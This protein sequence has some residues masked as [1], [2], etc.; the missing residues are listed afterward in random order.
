[1]GEW[2][3]DTFYSYFPSFN[4]LDQKRQNLAKDRQREYQEYLKR[5][6]ESEKPKR[7]P[8]KNNQVAPSPE[9]YETTYHQEKVEDKPPENSDTNIEDD[10]DKPESTKRKLLQDLRHTSLNTLVNGDGISDRNKESAEKE[11]KKKIEYQKQLLRQIEEKRKEVE[12]LKRR[13]KLEEE[14]LAKKL[15]EQLKTMQLEDELEKERIKAE[16][17]RLNIEQNQ[18]LRMKLLQNLSNDAKLLERRNPKTANDDNKVYKY[19]SNSSRS[20]YNK[21]SRESFFDISDS[22]SDQLSMPKSSGQFSPDDCIFYNNGVKMSRRLDYKSNESLENNSQENELSSCKNCQRPF[23]ASNKTRTK[24]CP[25]CLH[26]RNY[27]VDCMRS[28]C[29]YCGEVT[30]DTNTPLTTRSLPTNPSGRSQTNSNRSFKVLDISY[31]A[32]IKDFDYKL[33][34]QNSHPSYVVEKSYTSK[35]PPLTAYNPESKVIEPKL[36]MTSSRSNGATP[37]EDET[38][39]YV[40]ARNTNGRLSKYLRNYGDLSNKSLNFAK[41]NNSIKQDSQKSKISSMPLLREP[42]KKRVTK[43]RE[44]VVSKK[45]VTDN[46]RKLAQKWEIPAVQKNIVSPSSGVL[47]QLGAFRKQLQIEKLELDVDPTNQT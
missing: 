12:E 24:P 35:V 43:I 2:I 26:Q 37:G 27:C 16:K 15:E 6:S 25:H 30:L 31:G 14:L 7:N 36:I 38:N 21:Y 42:S 28:V 17:V 9:P 39:I 46:I 23:L 5:I 19:F 29:T 40:I 34:K 4:I 11:R 13:E 20:D 33:E 44:E 22:E 18:T 47:T 10:P 3:S 41:K 45:P 1:M 32:N 8:V